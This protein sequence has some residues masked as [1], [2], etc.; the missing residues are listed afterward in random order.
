MTKILIVDDEPMMLMVTKKIL[1]E[2]YEIICAGSAREAL[3][4]YPKEQPDMILTDLLMP[5]MTGFEMHK[6]LREKYSNEIPVMYMTADDADET[7]MQGLDLGAAD[8]IHKPFR[9]D[10]LLRRVENILDS[11]EKIKDLTEEATMDQMTGLYNKSGTV[12][13]LTDACAGQ[14]G[15]LLI[16]DLDSFKLVND[17]YG[18]D[19]GDSILKCFADVLRNNTRENDIKGRIGGD[20]FAAFLVN[21]KE[22]SRIATFSKAMNEEF[23]L[24]AKKILGEDMNI[25]LGVSIGAVKVPEN[26]TDYEELF[27]LADHELYGVKQNGKHGYSVHVGD[28]ELP[29]ETE[30]DP[31]EE[32]VRISRVLQ[33]RNVSNSALWLGQ[34]AFTNIYRFLV[35]FVSRYDVAA[36]KILFTLTPKDPEIKP[37]DFA[38]IMHAFGECVSTHLRKSDLLM[39]CKKNQFFLLLPE[40]DHENVK[41]VA[42]RIV[43]TF[44]KEGYMDKA[45]VQYLAAV[46][47]DEEE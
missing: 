5:E 17:L 47:N 24:G 28:E 12:Q 27:K 29:V 44:E 32:M 22:E 42:D 26:G 46:L 30:T 34:D 9:A 14:E 13:A 39:Q 7:E 2:K 25:P 23:L 43:S 21:T 35:R 10:V 19:F 18:H 4:L 16:I 3:D 41:L 6:L 45:D 38:E 15:F 1:S 37:D 11:R 8:F 20:E 33:E 36:H 40:L 31:G